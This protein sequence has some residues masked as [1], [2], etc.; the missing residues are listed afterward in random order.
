ME[1]TAGIGPSIHITGT[2]SAQEPLTIAGRVRGNID[3]PGYALTVTSSA[4]V[5]GDVTADHITISGKAQGR[6]RATSR[7]AVDDTA[8]VEGSLQTPVISVA[9]GAALQAD[10]VIE[11]RRPAALPLAS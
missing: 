9:A 10:C 4:D 11:G 7:I 2:I 3:V 6:L 8:T 1:S 5:N